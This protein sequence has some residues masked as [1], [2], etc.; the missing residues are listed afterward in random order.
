[1]HFAFACG[2]GQGHLN[3]TLPLVEELTAR[4]HRVS[5][6]IHPMYTEAVHA[7]GARVLPAYNRPPNLPGKWHPTLMMQMMEDHIADLKV[8]FPS[9]VETL[10]QDPPVAICHDAMMF[11]GQL[12]ADKL[13]VPRVPLNPTH[14]S[15]E[16]FSLGTAITPDT[17][18]HD[19]DFVAGF[20]RLQQLAADFAVE[21]GI[22]ES[23]AGDRSPA[24][25]NI[26]FIPREFQLEGDTFDERFRFVGPS[27]SRYEAA[28]TWRPADPTKPLLFISLGSGFTEQP[29]FYRMCFEAFGNSGWEVAMTIG[30]KVDP[31]DLPSVPDNFEIRPFFPQPAVL[32]HASVFLSHTGMNSTMESLH[33]GVPLVAV[34][35]MPEQEANAQ[36][37]EKLGVG[38]HLK[39]GELEPDVLRRTVD[40]VNAH[41]HTRAEVAT[42]SEVVRAGG[43]AVA[44]ANAIEDLVRDPTRPDRAEVRPASST[45]PTARSGARSAGS[46]HLDLG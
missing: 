44:A 15:H 43:G 10:Q 18:E 11:A 28:R 23:T 32:Q 39:S 6:W 40:E 35:Q 41:D 30:D 29:D 46:A 8:D 34:P 45:R 42:M 14:A 7:A 19:F 31:A 26:V 21:H 3:P 12:L 5:Y 38:R 25:L 4:G 17:S 2:P 37:V 9:I 36:Q 13:G 27:I 1:M 16:R 20:R 33:Y 22:S 24:G